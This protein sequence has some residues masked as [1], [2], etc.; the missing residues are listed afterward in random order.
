MQAL[1]IQEYN[2]HSFN[3]KLEEKNKKDQPCTQKKQKLM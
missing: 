1:D 2:N 3:E